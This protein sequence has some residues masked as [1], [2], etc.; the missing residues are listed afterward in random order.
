MQRVALD[1]SIPAR[2]LL[3]RGLCRKSNCFHYLCLTDGETEAQQ[4]KRPILG[5]GDDGYFTSRKL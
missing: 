3:P 4:V 5:R 1:S 2:S